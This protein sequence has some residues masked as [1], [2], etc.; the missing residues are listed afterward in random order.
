[1]HMKTSYSSKTPFDKKYP[2]VC[3]QCNN[4]WLREIDEAAQDAV[5]AVATGKRAWFRS[6]ELNAV[7]MHLTRT[8]LM[9]MWGTR[10]EVECPLAK[11]REFRHTQRPPEGTRIFAAWSEDAFVLAGGRHD[12]LNVNGDPETNMHLASWSM[13]RLF[14]LVIIPA[15]G[16]EPTSDTLARL[17]HRHGQRKVRLIWPAP[18]SSVVALRPIDPQLARRLSRPKILGTAEPTEVEVALPHHLTTRLERLQREGRM[19]SLIKFP[20]T[21]KLADAVTQQAP[22]SQA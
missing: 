10:Y 19:T 2:G 22:D 16:M 4:V 7:A 15:A 5:L 21:N 18:L 14:A 11:M 6:T 12:L 3:A 8:G 13:G 1:M 20:D 17:I 9:R